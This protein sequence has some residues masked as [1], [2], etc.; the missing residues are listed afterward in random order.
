MALIEKRHSTSVAWTKSADGGPDSFQILRR[1]RAAGERLQ[2]DTFATGRAGAR[3]PRYN[4][5]AIASRSA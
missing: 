4:A 3:T 1:V 2:S 5:E